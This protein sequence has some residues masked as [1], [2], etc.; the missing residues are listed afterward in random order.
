MLGDLESPA[1]VS[2]KNVLFETSK[3][4]LASVYVERNRYSDCAAVVLVVSG[5]VTI[6]KRVVTTFS[7]IV[8][9]IG[10]KLAFHCV[11][12]SNQQL[13]IEV[14][15]TIAMQQIIIDRHPR[16]RLP[17]QEYSQLSIIC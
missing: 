17:A 16:Y 14:A 8:H 7:F 3:S 5:F 1:E 6:T 10:N 4:I 13:R 9:E 11:L 15:P 2:S 12:Q